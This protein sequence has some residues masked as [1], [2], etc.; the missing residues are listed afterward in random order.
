[1]SFR[2]MI[3]LWLALYLLIIV[4]F[5]LSAL[6]RYITRFTEESFA[7]LIAIIFIVE[8]IKKIIAIADTHLYHTHQDIPLDY[9][10]YCVPKNQTENITTM[11][12]SYL[13]L[14]STMN[15][16]I[17]WNSIKKEDCVDLGGVLEGSGCN[18]HDNVFFLSII[19]GIGT[20]A[21]AWGLVMM[22]KSRFF[23]TIVSLKSLLFLLNLFPL[24]R[25]LLKITYIQIEMEL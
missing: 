1:M 11:P 21:I 19:L 25:V 9:T 5:D 22:K 14:N 3:G 24:I 7:C 6:V 17:Q 13:I 8:S 2:C 23:P 4:A 18:Y 10:C 16:T 20:F 12:N 15:L